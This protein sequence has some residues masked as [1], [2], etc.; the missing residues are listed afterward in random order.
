LVNDGV[1]DPV[2]VAEVEGDAFDFS[3]VFFDS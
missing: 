2:A 3:V 1:V